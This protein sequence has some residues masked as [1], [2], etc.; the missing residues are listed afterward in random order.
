MIK[1][2]KD[3]TFVHGGILPAGAVIKNFPDYRH[4]EEGVVVINEKIYYNEQALIDGKPPIN[5]SLIAEFANSIYFQSNRIMH[6]Q[7]ASEDDVNSP[8]KIEAK[9]LDLYKTI[10][11]STFVE[12]A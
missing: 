9:T 3:L 4:I 7:T 8:E 5:K 6:I 2:K 12:I 11:G 10:L 1:T